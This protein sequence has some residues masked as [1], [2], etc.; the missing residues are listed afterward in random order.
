MS[1]WYWIGYTIYKEAFRCMRRVY[2][3]TRPE[4]SVPLPTRDPLWLSINANMFDGTEEDV[5]DRV[6]L[7]LKEDDMVMPWKLTEITELK[8]VESWSYLTKTLEYNKIPS[9]GIAN[10]L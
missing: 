6:R 1:F 9:H 7:V 8:N 5:T 2:K 3:I 4:V 10:G